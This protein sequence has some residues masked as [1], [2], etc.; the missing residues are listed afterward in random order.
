MKST[1]LLLIMLSSLTGFGQT[2][3]VKAFDNA[4]NCTVVTNH[5]DQGQVSSKHF[6]NDKGKKHGVE[7]V[8]FEDGSIQYSR[9][10]VNGKLDGEGK[11]YHRNGNVYYEEIHSN[12]VK[13][14][15]WKFRDEDGDLTQSITYSGTGND[16]VYDYYHAG[17]KY[18][19][20]TVQK[21]KMVSESVLNTEIYEQ[22]K[23]EAEA[24]KE[25]GKQ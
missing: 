2:G 13:S 25:V 10:W 23:A 15:V 7:T 17:T 12:G 8:Y 22:L 24:A 9:N 1:L 16:G 14:G 21:G 6:E 5:Y 11:H 3:L 18:L 20:Q 4:C 19:T